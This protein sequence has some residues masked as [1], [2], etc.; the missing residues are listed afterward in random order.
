MVLA[1]LILKLWI[2]GKSSE[3]ILFESGGNI[4]N[5]PLLLCIIPYDAYGT[6]YS[7]NIASCFYHCR[8]CWFT[9][10]R[11]RSMVSPP[12]LQNQAH[13]SRLDSLPAKVMRFDRR[14]PPLGGG[15]FFQTG[16]RRR[17][18]KEAETSQRPPSEGYCFVCPYLYFLTLV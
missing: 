10:E 18:Y 1:L 12:A 9:F 17:K 14:K 8:L 16:V 15:G 7:D 11:V 2:H 6:P 13:G 3:R 5:N 4:V